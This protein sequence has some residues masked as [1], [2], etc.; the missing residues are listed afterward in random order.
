[1]Q[2]SISTISNVGRRIRFRNRK[3]LCGVK[4]EV[5]ISDSQANPDKLLFRCR[6]SSC[7]FFEWWSI[8]DDN[9]NYEDEEGHMSSSLRQDF[10]NNNAGLG[11]EVVDS[12]VNKQLEHSF[13]GLKS[14]VILLTMCVLMLFIVVVLK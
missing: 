7:N 13:R 9:I 1:M 14:V 6:S 3:C 8:E 4:A 5:R 10:S 12:M 2:G 11:E